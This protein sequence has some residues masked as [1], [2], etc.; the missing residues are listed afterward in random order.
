MLDFSYKELLFVDFSGQKNNWPRL[1]DFKTFDAEDAYLQS[2]TKLLI[3]YVDLYQAQG[4]GFRAG[5]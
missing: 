1:D 2:K 3:D 4:G 5:C